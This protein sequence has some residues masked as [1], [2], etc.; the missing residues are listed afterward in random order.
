M[1]TVIVVLISI[2]VL[3]DSSIGQTTTRQTRIY[4]EHSTRILTRINVDGL[5]KTSESVVLS[6]LDVTIG[7]ELTPSDLGE[8]FKRLYNLRIFSS[9]KFDL[10]KEGTN[11]TILT[12]HLKERW[13]LIPIAKAQ[14]GGGITQ[15]TLGAYDINSLGTFIEFGAQ[16]ENLNGNSGFVQWFRNPKLFGQRLR[17]GYDIWN[18]TRNRSLFTNSVPDGEVAEEIGGY[19]EHLERYNFF[20]DKEFV[21]WFNLGIGFERKRNVANT[22]DVSDEIRVKNDDN[23]IQMPGVLDEYAYYSYFRLG[24]LNYKNYLVDGFQS[25][26]NFRI[27]DS[28]IGGNESSRRVTQTTRY[29][30]L[31]PYEQNIGFNFSLGHTNSDNFQNNFFVGGLSHVRGFQDG[32]FIGQNFWQANF[33]YRVT[34]LR[35]RHFIVQ[36][37]LFFDIG[38]VSDEFSHLFSNS[39]KDPFQSIGTGVRIISPK[40]FRF[41]LRIDIAKAINYNK[42]TDISFGLQQ[43][44]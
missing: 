10:K 16:Y 43:F 32:Q 41:N 40:I 37:N 44:F 28:G 38:N 11:G 36:Q 9:I 8:S 31:L 23:G 42:V 18:V 25:D 34:S 12:I 29:F 21:Y 4:E 1:K 24:R 5:N 30:I 35:F 2:I 20:L 17:L 14:G 7:K 26:W 13:T 39:P 33:E 3:S 15:F 27:G 6:E 19:T 22:N